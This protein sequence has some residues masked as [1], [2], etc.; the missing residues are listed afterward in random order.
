MRIVWTTG[1]DADPRLSRVVQGVRGDAVVSAVVGGKPVYVTATDAHYDGDCARPHLHDCAAKMVQVWDAAT[2]EPVRTAHDVGGTHL[3]TTSVEGRPVAVVCDWSDTPKPI[4][5]ESGAVLDGIAGHR[6]VVVGL[7]TTVLDDGPA[8]VSVAWDE[9]LRVTH[10]ADGEVRVLASGER[11][12]DVSVVTVRGRP[13]AAVAGD[14][15]GLWD[16]ERG[17]RIGSLPVA[18]KIRKIATWPDG[19]GVLATLSWDGEVEVWDAASRTRLSRRMPGPQPAHDIAG[20]VTGDGRRLVALSDQEAV[21]LWDVDAGRPAERPLVGPTSWCALTDGGPGVVVTVS[22]ADEALAVW[23]VGTGTRHDDAGHSST[24]RCLTVAPGGHV[25]AGGTDGVVG[26]WRLEDGAR[27]AAAGAMPAQVHAVAA[28]PAG[29]GVAV[30]AGG[31]DLHGVTDDALHRWFDGG[32]DRPVA[33]DHRGEVRLVVPAVVD[34]RSIVLTAGC[35]TTLHI[36][37]LVTGERLGD[38]PGRHQPDGIAVGEL[39]GRPVA[40][41]S[42]AF[43]PFQLWDLREGAPIVTPVTEAMRP[44]ERVRA[45]VRLGEEPAIVTSRGHAVRV[46]DLGTGAAWHLA[47]DDIE[48]VTALAVHGGGRPL[49]AVARTDR[50]VTLFD[51]P[52]RAPLGVFTLPYP[53]TALAWAPDGDLI[54]GCRRDLLRVRR[55]E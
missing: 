3:V 53:A 36:T 29:D 22:H 9:T 12:N 37:D 15:V 19:N 34:G 38:I 17:E 40:A 41:V 32:P 28:V 33:V 54:V 10:L 55:A 47:P 16:L 48:H 2:G 31:G 35:G 52:T 21:H 14:G 45:F 43:G 27:E 42:R 7:A 30:V 24:V 26:S 23:R 46:M 51:L 1:S 4:D 13:V 18:S 25:L 11:F 6:G 49:A 5:L 39:G 20:V 50:S 8:V 44:A